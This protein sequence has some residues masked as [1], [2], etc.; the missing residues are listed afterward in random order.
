MRIDGSARPV[1]TC[2]DRALI[3][4][5]RRAYL[6]LTARGI[7][8]AQANASIDEAR[9][10]QDPYLRN[11]TRLAFLA[12]DIQRFILEGRQPPPQA[13]RSADPRAAAVLARATGATWLCMSRPCSAPVKPLHRSWSAPDHSLIRACWFPALVADRCCQTAL[14]SAEFRRSF[15]HRDDPGPLTSAHF[16]V[17]REIAASLA[18]GVWARAARDWQANGAGTRTMRGVGRYP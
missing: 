17:S 9:G 14:S 4:G 10:V 16:L 1:K 18:K 3:D 12:P 13:G 7:H 6:E 5:L 8:L 15:A 11:L 2:P